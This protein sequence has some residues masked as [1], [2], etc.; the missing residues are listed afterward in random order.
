MH[1]YSHSRGGFTLVEIMIVVVLI[2]LLAALAIPAYQKVRENAIRSEMDNDARMLASAAHQYF[3]E[4][5]ATQV[6]VTIAPDGGVGGV[7]SAYVHKVAYGYGFAPATLPLDTGFAMTHP[8]ISVTA[9]YSA[10]GQRQ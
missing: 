3:L 8:L 4:S 5:N 9:N 6:V 7:L 2:G 10:N 1:H